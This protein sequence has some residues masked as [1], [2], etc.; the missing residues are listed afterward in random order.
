MK[1]MPLYTHAGFT[2][3][4]VLIAMVIFSIGILGVSAMQLT[5]IGG[6]SKANSVSKVSNYASDRIETIMSLDYADPLLNDDDNDG[7]SQD[8]NADG[9]DDD[10][11]NF[12]LDDLVNP[13][14]HVVS[15][16]G[17]YDIF[18]NVA[19][20]HPVVDSKTIKVIVRQKGSKKIVS[21]ETIKEN[22]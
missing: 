17:R 5:A 7:T 18:W 11:G 16:D 21:L 14:G 15:A 3:L 2:L 8:A 9:I 12:G 1:N 13:D 4:E 6:N 20:N 22:S 19:I 10:G